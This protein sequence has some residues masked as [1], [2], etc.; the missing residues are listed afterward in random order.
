MVEY[1]DTK[2]SVKRYADEVSI[3]K[4]KYYL[5]ALLVFA[6][7][8]IGFFLAH[9]SFDKLPLLIVSI[10]FLILT[11]IISIIVLIYRY[12]IIKWFDNKYEELEIDGKIKTTLEFS[13]GYL[14][15]KDNEKVRKY[16]EEDIIKALY[17]KGLIILVTKNE[18]IYLM[19]TKEC[20]FFLAK[21]IR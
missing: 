21:Y 19:R 3:Q 6:S 17:S 8:S 2:D 13:D 1:V 7:L 18:N 14:V 10:I 15:I 5:I 9:I 16:K 11:I 12:R 20:E 4:L